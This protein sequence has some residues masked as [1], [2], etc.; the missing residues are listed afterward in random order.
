MN[1][2][3]TLLLTLPATLL[4][5]C[6][7]TPPSED[8]VLIK[9]DELDRRLQAIERVVEN[10]S[11]VQ[12]N[13]QVA[14]LERRADELQGIAETIAYDASTTADRQRQ[15]YLDLDQRIQQLEA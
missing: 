12:L 1:I 5:G 7:L 8:P 2:R 10:Q 4:A 11:L 6:M 13:Q 3:K 14:A 9:L 15:L